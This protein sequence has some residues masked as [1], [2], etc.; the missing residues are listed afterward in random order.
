MKERT[1][2]AFF[3]SVLLLSMILSLGFWPRHWL[4]AIRRSLLGVL[5]SASGSVNFPLAPIFLFIVIALVVFCLRRPRK[6]GWALISLLLGLFLLFSITFGQSY[7]TEYFS[8]QKRYGEKADSATLEKLAKALLAQAKKEEI[9]VPRDGNKGL[10]TPQINQE[11]PVATLFPELDQKA[12][13]GKAFVPGVLFSKLGIVGMFFPFTGEVFYNNEGPKVF[14]GHSI[15]HECAHFNGVARE[16]EANFQGYLLT[17]TSP[18]AYCRYSGTMAAL[19]QVL[20]NL[21]ARDPKAALGIEEGFSQTMRQDRRDYDD[22]WRK[23]KGPLSDLQREVNDSYL[24]ASGDPS[25]VASYDE[26]CQYLLGHYL[27]EEGI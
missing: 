22:Y 17:R 8:E 21:K 1:S 13:K 23:Q 3:V 10:L 12:Q 18:D 19:E 14:L 16:G 9:L 2:K 20:Y 24:K 6:R 11:A 15:A 25:G 27:M 5:H 7:Q 26:F 4:K